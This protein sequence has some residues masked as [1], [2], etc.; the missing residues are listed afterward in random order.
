MK[1]WTVETPGHFSTS[2][3]L[4][5]KGA[6]V[7]PEDGV[8]FQVTAAALN[9]P[10]LLII[11]GKYQFK[12]PLPFSPGLEAVGV[13]TKAGAKSQFNPGQRVVCFHQY[14][15]Y[16][17]YCAAADSSLFVVPNTMTD[18]HAAGMMVTYQ[19]SYFALVHRA[20]LAKGETLLVHGGAGGVGSS[21]IQI[22]KILGAKVIATAGSDD[23]LEICRRAGADHVINY[24][25]NDFVE[26]VKA[27]TSNRGADVIYDPVGGEVFEKSTKC[28]A[29]CGRLVVVGFAS[30]QIPSIAANRILLKN[31]SI[32]GLH[33]GN[34]FRQDIALVRAAHEKLIE[35]YEEE[36]FRPFIYKEFPFEEL[37]AALRALEQ[38][39]SHGKIILTG[40]SAKQT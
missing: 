37:P 39:E 15:S 8:V 14:G 20:Q 12:P 18:S 4:R 31:I 11:A 21:A 30:G 29:W 16:A 1:A 5:E 2:L 9:F 28:I 35:W 36:R 23:K 40:A 7:C 25:D 24:R 38:R 22:G 34:Y 10:D 13:V 17:E 27:L 19:T 3:G 26:T 32:V 6:P 33:W